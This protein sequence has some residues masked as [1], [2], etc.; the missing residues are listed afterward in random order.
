MYSQR[1]RRP[2]VPYRRGTQSPSSDH[3]GVPLHDYC[4]RKGVLLSRRCHPARGHAGVLL[5]GSSR[6]SEIVI[7]P[8]GW[9]YADR[10]ETSRNL[11][12]IA[13]LET[14]EMPGPV[15]GV[16]PGRKVL[17]PRFLA[18]MMGTAQNFEH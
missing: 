1:R 17:T 18:F 5:E 9:R 14:A 10:F 8:L 7:L 16:E 11:A 13:S 4:A 2:F 15:R 3:H 6:A 12:V